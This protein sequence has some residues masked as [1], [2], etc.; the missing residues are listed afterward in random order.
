MPV[1]GVGD[2]EVLRCRKCSSYNTR[3]TVTESREDV[4]WRYCRCLDCGERFKTVERYAYAKRT[5]LG[6]N[7]QLKGCDNYNS[8]F[9]PA[10]IVDIRSLSEDGL[11][12]AQIALRYGCDRSTIH[13]IVNYKT[14]TDEY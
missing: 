14:Y 11:S 1:V 10:D 13:K 8:R 4:T 7:P 5:P 12:G 3:V 6:L 9:T 2:E